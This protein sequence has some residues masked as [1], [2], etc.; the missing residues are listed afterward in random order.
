MVEAEEVG[1]A[2][3]REPMRTRV[4]AWPRGPAFLLLAALLMIAGY[5]LW[6]E[7][8]PVPTL[9]A[10]GAARSDPALYRAIAARVTG[11][12]GYYRAAVAEHRARA[13]PLRPFVAIRLPTLAL[14]TAAVGGT[15]A[16]GPI[17]VLL[18]W[19]TLGVTVLRLRR[20]GLPAPVWIAASV[21]AACSVALIAQPDFAVWHEAWA[22]L[23][24][25]LSLACRG[26]RRWGASVVPGLVAVLMRELALPYL[27]AMMFAAAIERRKSEVLGWGLALLV[28][29]GALALHA[30]QVTALVHP[31]DL[32]SPGWSHMAGWRFD[33]AVVRDSSPLALLPALVSALAVPAALFGWAA[34]PGA[35]PRRVALTLAGWLIP[36]LLIGRL[37]NSY[38]GLL[39]APLALAGLAFAVP[40]SIDLVRAAFPAG[41]AR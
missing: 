41:R 21:L 24:I 10:E 17:F 28:A 9:R 26:E 33:L 1:E 11:G 19:L 39:M 29:L 4:A 14:V 23:L 31:D 27:V 12:E 22:G 32:A 18:A 37:D 25:A 20:L 40:A 8:R 2:P 34:C 13:Y 35:Y 5:G 38:W 15:K 3:A 7:S 6:L 16:V 30:G 36:F